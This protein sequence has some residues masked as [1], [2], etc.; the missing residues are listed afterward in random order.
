MGPPVASYVPGEQAKRGALLR[1]GR[2]DQVLRLQHGDLE[3]DLVTRKVSRGGRA[4]EL[5]VREFE[6]LE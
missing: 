4:L 1:S 3:M 2:P 6:I 5:T